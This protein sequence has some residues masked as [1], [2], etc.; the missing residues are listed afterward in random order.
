M[1]AYIY[2]FNNSYV[3]FSFGDGGKTYKSFKTKEEAI[4]NLIEL[5]IKNIVIKE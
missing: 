3:L 1:E 5:K 4:N 2:L